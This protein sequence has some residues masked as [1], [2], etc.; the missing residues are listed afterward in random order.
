MDVFNPVMKYIRLHYYFGQI[1]SK[2]V[3]RL[4]AGFWQAMAVLIAVLCGHR[5]TNI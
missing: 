1:P 3:R 4:T 2:N 5:I